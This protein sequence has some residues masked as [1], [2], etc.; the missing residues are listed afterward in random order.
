YN[1]HEPATHAMF[2][3]KGKQ[4]LNFHNRLIGY[5]EL[6]GYDNHFWQMSMFGYLRIAMVMAHDHSDTHRHLEYAYNLALAKFPIVGPS[7]GGWANGHGYFHVNDVTLLGVP[8][9]LQL[10]GIDFIKNH[11]WYKNTA[12]YLAYSVG[13]GSTVPG[14]GDK[15]EGRT[16]N[17]Y[18]MEMNLL[19]QQ[20]KDSPLAAWTLKQEKRRNSRTRFSDWAYIINDFVREDWANAPQPKELAGAA[21]FRGVGLAALHSDITNPKENTVV[22]LHSSP[23]GGGVAHMT[24]SQNCFNIS[25]KGLPL[26][27]HTGNYKAG[28]SSKHIYTDYRH[29]RSHNG[30]LVNGLSQGS[31]MNYFGWIKHFAEN[32]QIAYAC[33]DATQAYGKVDENAATH[34]RGKFGYGYLET[35]LVRYDR[36]VAFCRPN[37]LVVYDDIEAKEECDFSLMFNSRSQDAVLS[38]TGVFTVGNAKG[39]GAL[40][41]FSNVQLEHSFSNS[42]LTAFRQEKPSRAEY[43]VPNKSKKAR[44]LTIIQLNDKKESVTEVLQMKNGAVSGHGFSIKAQLDPK[45]PAELSISGKA[46]LLSIQQG[47]NP[48]LQG[49]VQNIPVKKVAEF[50]PPIR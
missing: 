28:F 2:I 11:P 21:V 35:P 39:R 5:L 18:G 17:M 32:D 15:S 40:Q 9:D 49:R 3:A 50:L 16:Y 36:H 4:V 33:G 29:T 24:S 43:K 38:D 7:D 8:R 20:I 47:A 19:F 25:Y 34:R 1:H 31:G 30:L 14:F 45:Q 27:Y 37:L 26:F 6:K 41:V 48:V 22:Y 46:S 42:Y 23:Y 44:F 13:H 12:D 10:G